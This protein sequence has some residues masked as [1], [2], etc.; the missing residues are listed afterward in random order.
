MTTT[1]F[2]ATATLLTCP[3]AN[4][5][6][7]LDG[8]VLVTGGAFQVSGVIEDYFVTAELYDPDTN[9]WSAT[10]GI[11]AES[12]YDHRATLLADGRVLVSGGAATVG[13][14][15]T[16]RQ[17]AEIYNPA[18]NSFDVV[19]PMLTARSHHEATLLACP[20]VNPECGWGGKVL[21]TG[22]YTQGTVV[23]AELFNPATGAFAATGAMN[24]RR[25]DHTATRLANGTIL[26]AGGQT[27]F[28]S[29]TVAIPGELYN[30]A[31]GSFAVTGA[32][33]NGRRRA[34]ATLLDDG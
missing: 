30:P 14:V 25:G 31:T 6:C 27:A 29:P 19:V 2:E 8:K 20:A 13:G 9:T 3:A 22:G 28:G 11:M 4:P 21:V 1:R 32:M 34:S 17:T 10:A 18:T 7:P 33:V 26:I 5:E 24:Y 23:S 16:R 15:F 12:R